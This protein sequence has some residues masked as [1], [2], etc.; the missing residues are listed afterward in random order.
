MNL[1][2]HDVFCDVRAET[3]FTARVVD[4]YDDDEDSHAHSLV[5]SVLSLPISLFPTTSLF[6]D[7]E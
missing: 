1:F 2:H 4:C 5:L 6:P 7:A 3:R